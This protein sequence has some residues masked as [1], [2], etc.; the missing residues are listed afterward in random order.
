MAKIYIVDSAEFKKNYDRY[1]RGSVFHQDIADGKTRIKS[2]S[3]GGIAHV[4][5]VL[6]DEN[7]VLSADVE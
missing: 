4:K 6:G 3:E 2:A 1:F 5:N 7:V